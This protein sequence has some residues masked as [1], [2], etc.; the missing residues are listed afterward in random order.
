VTSVDV[1]PDYID[2]LNS[3]GLKAQRTEEF[4]AQ[5]VEKF[6]LILLSHVI[7]HLTPGNW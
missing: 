6:D 7:E 3:Q 5:P 2:I 4:F 1:N